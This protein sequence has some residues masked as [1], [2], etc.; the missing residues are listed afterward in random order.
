MALNN[1][2]NMAK[3]YKDKGE[4]IEIEFAPTVPASV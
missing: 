3:F 2:E 1:A 4:K